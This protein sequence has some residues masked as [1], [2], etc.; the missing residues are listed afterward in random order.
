MANAQGARVKGLFRLL[1]DGGG[2]AYF[3]EG[4]EEG[5]EV[6]FVGVE[7]DGD[8]FGFEVTDEV[9]DPFLEGDILH[10]LIAAGL[11]V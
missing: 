2:F 7:G 11:T 9:L 1:F 3:V 10:D 6:G 8:G 4:F 5:V